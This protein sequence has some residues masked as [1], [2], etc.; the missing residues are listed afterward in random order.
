MCGIGGMF[1]KDGRC[2]DRADLVA[3]GETMFLRGPDGEGFYTDGPVG[4]VH[5]RLAVIDLA[6]GAQ[7]IFNED[8][9]VVTVVNGEFYNFPALRAMLEQRGHRFRTNSD[10]ECAV[11]LYEEVGEDF[12]FILDGMFALALYDVRKKS[13]L[14]ARD[15]AGE[16][17]LF[18]LDTPELF[19]FA[20][21]LNALKRIAPTSPRLNS[22]A[23]VDYLNMLYTPGRET[24]YQGMTRLDP[25]SLLLVS[26]GTKRFRRYETFDS[27]EEMFLGKDAIQFPHP[28]FASCAQE[29]REVVTESV[30]A[31]LAS[32]VP[33]GVFLSGG[34]DSTI[35]ASVASR[36]ESSEP[37]RCFSIAFPDPAYDESRQAK[38]NAE[39]IRTH[40]KRPVEF[41]CRTV[42]PEDFASL[43]FLLARCG[44]P[45]G[46]SSILPTY[47]LCRF[48]RES[49]TVALSGDGADELF[50]GYERYLV[51]RKLR[52]LDWIPE[53]MR[54]PLFNL[55]AGM[56]SGAGGD[57]TRSSRLRRL[58]LAAGRN[59]E[60]RYRSLISCFSMDELRRLCQFSLPEEKM[61]VFELYFDP[62]LPDPA[63]M[64]DFHVYLPNDILRKTDTAS[65][66]VSLE[67]RAP[68]LDHHLI[69]LAQSLPISYKMRGMRRKIVLGEAFRDWIPPELLRNRKKGFGIPLASW[70][71]GPWREALRSCLLDGKQCRALFERSEVERLLS[72]HLSGWADHSRKLYALLT[73]ELGLS[74]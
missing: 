10:S 58:L 66:A 30:R 15:R 9:T 29:V 38:R 65:M 45:Y 17:P 3:M 21:D 2:V 14:L 41:H 28:D 73:V 42:Q 32:D 34:M 22:A 71:R 24:V 31:R 23:L 16:K 69:H 57:R 40:A 55:A 13:L 67:V 39:W 26:E 60:S 19:A 36:L 70:F 47:L 35:L 49:V 18:L 7:P 20:S 27:S 54:R 5:R 50:G 8:G 63:P 51:M 61:E 64:F 53:G 25:G 44:E 43:E 37:L 74:N 59:P 48:A 4:L 68:Y 11:H 56:F 1:R 46:D 6:G 33:L 12:P 52:M 62:S 72:E